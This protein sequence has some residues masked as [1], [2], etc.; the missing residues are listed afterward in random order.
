MPEVKCGNVGV[1][2]EYL[3]RPKDMNGDMY[4]TEGMY[5]GQQIFDLHAAKWEM[6]SITHWV[7][8]T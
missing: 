2:G 8:M 6:D 1:S 5:K 4:K 3:S 7:A